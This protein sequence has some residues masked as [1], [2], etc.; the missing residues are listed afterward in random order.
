MEVMFLGCKS[1]KS[2]DVSSFNTQNITSMREIFH[3]CESLESLNLSNFN[4]NK[5]TDIDLMFGDDL[6]LTNLDLSSFNLSESK[7]LEYMLHYTPAPSTILLAS[8]SPIKTATT[9]YQDEA[10][11]IIAPARVYGGP[12]LEAY[13]FDQKSIPGYTFKRVIGN[14]TGILCKSP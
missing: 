9:S 11:N 1:L 6:S 13:S 7:D 14:L 5:L 8:N 2:F 4:T 3:R 10:G 12:L